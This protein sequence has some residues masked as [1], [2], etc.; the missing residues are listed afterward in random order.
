MCALESDFILL[1]DKKELT[2]ISLHM[3]IA[4]R[5]KINKVNLRL[6]LLV[7]LLRNV[8]QL[9][10]FGVHYPILQTV[11]HSKCLLSLL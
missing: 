10:H 1:Y 4:F 2:S 7:L 9:V 3:N 11:L 5:S 8:C 6:G